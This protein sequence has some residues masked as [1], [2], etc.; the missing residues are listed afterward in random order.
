MGII[1]CYLTKRPMMRINELIKCFDVCL[2]K[3]FLNAH[4]VRIPAL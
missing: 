4:T 1:L 2:Q 3:P